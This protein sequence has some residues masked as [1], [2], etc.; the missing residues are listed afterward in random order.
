MSSSQP[1][2]HRPGQTVRWLAVAAGAVLLASCRS[3]SLTVPV[4]AVTPLPAVIAS[5]AVAEPSDA[6]K[7]AATPQAEDR[8]AAAE[9]SELP[10]VAPTIRDGEV[11]STG[12]EL[13]SPSLPRLGQAGGAT[14]LPADATAI[15]GG[16]CQG[17]ECHQN[18]PH[19]IREGGCGSPRCRLHACRIFGAHASAG[20]Q[21]GN[22]KLAAAAPSFPRL[23]SRS[24]GRALSVTAVITASRPYPAAGI[25]SAISPPATRSPATAPMDLVLRRKTNPASKRRV[26]SSLP[27]APASTRRGSRR[28][29]G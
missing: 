17:T 22:A 16:T 29:V 28:S 24:S 3:M 2:A 15:G 26:V 6:E 12:L 10:L 18:A 19:G 14:P 13:P 1:A 11:H 8:A 9:A 25:A 21:G 5:A 20:C 27:T 23:L 4:A 7:S